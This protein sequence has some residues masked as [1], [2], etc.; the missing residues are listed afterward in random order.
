MEYLL[1]SQ[2]I[3]MTEQKAALA[4]DT[5]KDRF[6]DIKMTDSAFIDNNSRVYD[7][8]IPGIFSTLKEQVLTST[9]K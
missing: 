9:I 2:I 7:A 6:A 1:Y 5:F 3:Y 8:L 4:A